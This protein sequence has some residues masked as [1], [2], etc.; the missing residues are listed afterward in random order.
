[1]FSQLKTLWAVF[2]HLFMRNETVQYPEEMPYLA[3]RYRGRIVLTRDPSGE[4]RC[5]ACNLCAVVCPVDCIALQKTETED[6]RWYPESFRIN[7]SRCIMCGMCE[8]ACPTYAIQLTPDF[9]L[10]E[11]ERQNLVYEKEH[12]LIDGGGKY[13]DYSFW[14][15]S[16]KTIE[17]KSKGQAERESPPVNVRS[18]LP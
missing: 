5:V 2:S 4:E 16:G 9:E 15:V 10:C 11:Y 12:L 1:V 3:P 7:F 13:P 18:L 6:G 8:E 14:E 17:G